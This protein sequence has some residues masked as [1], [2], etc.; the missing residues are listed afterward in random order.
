MDCIVCLICE[1]VTD[2]WVMWCSTYVE[3]P[4]FFCS[5]A[6]L[7]AWLVRPTIEVKE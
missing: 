6:C 1:N 2:D 3:E 4:A 7:A 5:N